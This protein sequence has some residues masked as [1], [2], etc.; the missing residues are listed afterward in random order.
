MDHKYKQIIGLKSGLVLH[1]YRQHYKKMFTMTWLPWQHFQGALHIIMQCPSL[2]SSKRQNESNTSSVWCDLGVFKRSQDGM[3]LLH[4]LLY[5]QSIVRCLMCQ[6]EVKWIHIY[7]LCIN[8]TW[9]Q[10]DLHRPLQSF[11]FNKHCYNFNRWQCP[12]LWKAITIGIRI[13]PCCDPFLQVNK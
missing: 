8:C 11:L 9:C 3:A 6:K 2:Y 7:R 5:H 1:N 12:L 13:F 10:W 4:Y